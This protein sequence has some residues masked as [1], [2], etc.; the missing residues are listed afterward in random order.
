MKHRRRP[1][2]S[3]SQVASKLFLF[4]ALSSLLLSCC[5][6]D[7]TKSNLRR[8]ATMTANNNENGMNYYDAASSL[9][10][11][12]YVQTYKEEKKLHPTSSSETETL[13]LVSFRGWVIFFLYG[14]FP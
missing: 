11:G 4:V 5:T 8:T 3:S 2:S 6:A 1:N 12:K 7:E 13:T 10:V 9:P 14:V